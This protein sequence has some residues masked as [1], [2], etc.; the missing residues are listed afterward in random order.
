MNKNMIINGINNESVTIYEELVDYGFEDIVFIDS[1]IN[2]V[3][4]FNNNVFIHI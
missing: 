1:D 2:K 4:Q 3:K